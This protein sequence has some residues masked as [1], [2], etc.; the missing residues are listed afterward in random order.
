MTIYIDV[1]AAV[2]SKAGL[3]RYSEKLATALSEQQPG[4][5][6]LFHNQGANGRLPAP[7]A[8]LPRRAVPYGYKPWRMMV[9]LGQMAR[10]PFNRLVPGAELFH[11]TEHLLLPLR[12]IPT[13]LTMHDL[14]FKLFPEYH[15]KLN[16]WYLNAAVPL[17]C[18]RAH[19]IIAISEAT[20]RDLIA[21]YAIPEAKIAVV[22]E[23][24]ADHFRPPTAE[25]IAAVRQKYDLPAQF[26]IHLSTIEPRKNLPRLV[27]AL[28]QLRQ[29]HPQLHLI[30]VGAKGWLYDDFFAQI[31]ADGLQNS[32]RSLGWVEDGDLP[33]V[34][35]A[36]DLA[37]QPSLY[38]GFGLPV[39]EHMAVGQVV[40]ASNTSSLPEVGGTAA[41]YF[42]PTSVDEITAVLH[43]LLTSPEERTTRRALGLARSAEFSWAKT[44]EA[45][46]RVYR[47]VLSA[48]C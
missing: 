43:R 38:E 7:L 39:L 4:R 25:Q 26:L 45:T 21:H 40:A 9:L 17:F 6:A 31:A 34:L 14:I 23:A 29:H 5:I 18:R 11:A 10:L 8:H 41:A 48:E 16:Y 30:L 28:R 32:V 44:A 33:A 37:V 20:K 3:G 36:A 46:L 35:A 1:S 42:D 12:G 22:Y 47:E 13:V 15:K 27:A 19:K 2:H 24:A